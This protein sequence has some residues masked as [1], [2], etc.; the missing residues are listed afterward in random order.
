MT[1]SLKD[2]S[3]HCKSLSHSP[4]MQSI[5]FDVHFTCVQATLITLILSA[6]LNEPL[7]SCILNSENICQLISG[8]SLNQSAQIV[9]SDPACSRIT[10][11][12]P[13]N[14]L[15]ARGQ[16]SSDSENQ[17]AAPIITINYSFQAPP[18]SQQFTKQPGTTTMKNLER[19]SG[20]I[21]VS[22][23][24]LMSTQDD[25]SFISS[26][27]MVRPLLPLTCNEIQSM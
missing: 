11:K 10:G 15:P 2:I 9:S 8:S 25:L 13:T 26:S 27:K 3:H 7:P 16:L 1:S 19:F 5:I 4:Q 21:P 18:D 6:S 23:P 20:K 14:F 22:F 17:K 12:C 24:R